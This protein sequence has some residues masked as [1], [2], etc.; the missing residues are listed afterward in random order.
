MRISG[1]EKV[2]IKLSALFAF[3]VIKPHFT[4]KHRSK[5]PDDPELRGRARGGA[6][7]W[8]SELGAG[9]RLHSARHHGNK[10]WTGGHVCDLAAQ[11]PG[12]T[13]IPLQ[14]PLWRR[15]T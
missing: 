8:G 5:V 6:G 7:G 12:L 14:T 2:I 10:G 15:S 11:T 4:T 9:P 1:D 3:R 13:E